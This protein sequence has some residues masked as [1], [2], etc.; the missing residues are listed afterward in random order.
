MNIA[1]IGTFMAGVYS[2]LIWTLAAKSLG[3][4][5]AYSFVGIV[6]GLLD[7]S[8]RHKLHEADNSRCSL[9]HSRACWS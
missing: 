3:G 8:R 1:A 4:S 6:A 7:T 5:I 9:G 2:L